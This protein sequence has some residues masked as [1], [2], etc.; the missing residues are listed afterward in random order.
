[1]PTAMPATIAIQRARDIVGE[2]G[3]HV[4]LARDRPHPV[5]DALFIANVRDQRGI[6]R[7]IEEI[8]EE[9]EKGMPF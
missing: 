7:P 9:I 4:L 5:L 6:G 8:I 1:M 2:P 3:G